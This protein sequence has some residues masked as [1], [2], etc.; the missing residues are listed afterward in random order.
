M[1]VGLRILIVEDDKHIR[2][3]LESLLTKEESLVAHKAEVLVASDG[4]EGLDVLD[5][6]PLDLVISDLLMPRMDGFA[7]ARELRKHKHGATV[8]LIVTS[9]LYKDQPTINRLQHESGA[10]FFSKPFQVRE[11][12]AAIK[13]LLNL[14]APPATTTPPLTVSASQPARKDPS[15]K[16]SAANPTAGSLAERT[17]PL[18]LLELW[19]QRVTGTLTLQRGKVKKVVTL[20]HGTPVHATSNLRTETLGHFLVARGVLDEQRHREA[21][22]RAQESQERIG[23]ALVELGWMSDQD[24][25]KQLAAQMRTKLVNLLRWKEGDWM[26]QPGLDGVPAV[27]TPVE[28]PRMIFSGLAKTAHVDEVAQQ[29]AAVRG[30][31]AL[32]LRAER[33]REAFVRVFGDKGLIAL[34]RRPL[35][36]ELLVAGDPTP[37]LVQL[38]TLLACAMAEVDSAAVPRREPPKPTE[39]ADPIALQRLP[40]RAH[41]VVEAPPPPSSN[42]LYDQLFG[43]EPTQ[44]REAATLPLLS[45]G[46]DADE[47]SGVMQVPRG[48]DRRTPA[49]GAA[50][51]ATPP[52]NAFEE[53]HAEQLRQEVL[54]D[55]LAMQGKDAYTILRV[56]PQATH[57]QIQAAYQALLRRF[58]LSRFANVDL[59]PDYARLDEIHQLLKSAYDRLSD[60]EARARHDRELPNTARVQKAALAAELLAQQAQQQLDAGQPAAALELIERALAAAPAEAD[61]HALAAW[62]RFQAEGGDSAAAQRAWPELDAAFEIDR[63]H[64]GAHEFA[65]RIAAATGADER[66][67]EHLQ[68]VLDQEPTRAQALIAYEAACARRGEHRRLERQYRKLIHRLGDDRDPE[69]ALQLWWRLAELYRTRL[70]DRESA[71]LAYEIAAKL[72]PDDPRPREALVRLHGGDPNAWREQARALR[73]SWRVAPEDP[74]AGRA[75]FALH[76]DGQRWDAAFAVAAALAVRGAGEPASTELLRRYQPRFLPR[77][78]SS[79]DGKNLGRLLDS[80]RHPDDDAD[81]SQLF[82]RV[83]ASWQPTFTL[84]ALGVKPDDAIERVALPAPFAQVLG[85]VSE[86]LGV[87][88]PPV[89]RRG[90]FG[91]EVHVG[92]SR[93]PILLAGPQALSTSDKPALAFRLGRALTFLL[94]GRAVAGALPPRQL[95]ATLLATLTLAVPALRVEDPDGEIA[96]VRAQLAQA[97]PTLG[98]DVARGCERLIKGPQATLNLSRYTRGLARTADRVGMLLCNSLALAVRIVMQA[99]APGAEHDL[100]D[101]A[102]SDEYLAAREALSLSIAV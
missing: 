78:H 15:V 4:K 51:L 102:L 2:K 50:V 79:L 97:A 53:A 23:E 65:G 60:R 29:L 48:L 3:I 43:D 92:A 26:F 74:A 30:R 21:L 11:M 9:A 1:R 68:R 85:Y 17:P 5:K 98:R 39:K 100:V 36:E 101:F 83:F 76:H 37:M 16:I 33:H 47:L 72:A 81:L 82:A 91:L 32:T 63:D 62:A 94:P 55:Y 22:S 84:E 24:L 18:M 99:A 52:L 6:G 86:Q 45:D 95:K 89:Y 25:I 13:K 77:A 7:F 56:E 19:E 41:T 90:D 8:P 66:A 67:I 44:V 57:E 35:L 46:L 73:D 64:V 69:R 96:R 40:A 31:I 88:P 58:D 20:I 70:D 75:L 49:H 27:Q 80:I 93:P 10:Q 34:Q 42:S 87:A 59:G 61:Y 12:L 28:A 71:R 54:H 14:N 38:D